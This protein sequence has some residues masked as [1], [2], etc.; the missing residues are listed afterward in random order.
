MRSEEEKSQEAEQK[1][2]I[3]KPIENLNLKETIIKGNC[4]ISLW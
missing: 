3:E 2:I 1:I 4:Q